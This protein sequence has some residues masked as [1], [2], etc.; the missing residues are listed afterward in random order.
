MTQFARSRGLPE[1][2]ESL[3]R[4]SVESVE[5]FWAAIWDQYGVEGSYETVLA[6]ARDARRARGSRA[7]A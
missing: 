1:D 4:W 3:W 5:D 7:R 6:V 2:Y